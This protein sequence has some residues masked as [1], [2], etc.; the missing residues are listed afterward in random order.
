MGTFPRQFD[1]LFDADSPS[2]ACAGRSRRTSL[3]RQ[4]AF[5]L[6]IT[7]PSVSAT[8]RRSNQSDQFSM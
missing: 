7:C 3:I 4:Y 1:A 6:R 8:I 2:R 5:R